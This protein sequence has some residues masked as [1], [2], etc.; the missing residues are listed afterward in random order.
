MADK[1]AFSLAGFTL[2]VL[3][4]GMATVLFLSGADEPDV[5]A[6][7]LMLATLAVTAPLAVWFGLRVAS[8]QRARSER[9]KRA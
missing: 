9:D 2:F 6:I 7:A 3:F 8:R 4:G 1:L 5:T